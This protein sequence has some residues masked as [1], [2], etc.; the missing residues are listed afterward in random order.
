VNKK[1]VSRLHERTVA[2]Y[3]GG[4][5]SRSSGASDTDKGDVRVKSSRT[6]FECKATGAPGGESKYTTVIRQLEKVADEAWSEGKSPALALRYF[7]PD[8]PLASVDGWLD[9]TVRLTKDDAE[10][11]SWLSS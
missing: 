9:L 4:V 7:C 10:R 3:Y 1:D 8:S 11:E 2:S 6:I 5:P